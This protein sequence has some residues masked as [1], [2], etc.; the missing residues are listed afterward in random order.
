MQNL[1]SPD[2]SAALFF[3]LHD[4]PTKPQTCKGC[5]G[6]FELRFGPEPCL[7]GHSCSVTP[8]WPAA[9]VL[10]IVCH[11]QALQIFIPAVLVCIQYVPVVNYSFIKVQSVQFLIE[12]SWM[13]VLIMHTAFCHSKLLRTFL[14]VNQYYVLY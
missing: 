11:M 1:F 14:S 6:V 9:P 3:L 5:A 13:S 4:K 12:M 2:I 8:T 10:C 7:V